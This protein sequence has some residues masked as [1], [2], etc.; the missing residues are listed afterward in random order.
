[1]HCIMMIVFIYIYFNFETFAILG[2][3]STSLNSLTV[4]LYS[5]RF[6]LLCSIYFSILFND[7]QFHI[8]VK[9]P[10]PV[11]CGE[12][13]ELVDGQCQAIPTE[14]ETVPEEE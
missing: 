7:L 3:L 8:S 1:M 10:T 5:S 9:E 11:E 6:C 13:E 12:G 4:F 2:V 14:E